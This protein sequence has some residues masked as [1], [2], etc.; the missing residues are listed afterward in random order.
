LMD[1]TPFMSI[2]EPM[3]DFRITHSD[4]MAFAI[5]PSQLRPIH[6]LLGRESAKE[7]HRILGEL[8]ADMDGRPTIRTQ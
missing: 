2:N 1:Q 4:G 5:K 8:L 3:M 7:I 6:V